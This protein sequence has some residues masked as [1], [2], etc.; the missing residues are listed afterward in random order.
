MKHAIIGTAG[1]VDHGKTALVKA[2]TGTDCDR[3]KEEKERGLTIELG[4]AYLDLGDGKGASIVDVPGHERF[5]KTMLAGAGVIDC[6]LFVIA[7]DEG[8]MPQTIEHFDIINLLGIKHGLI[9]LTK[10]DLTGREWLQLVKEDIAEL[11]R[12]TPFETAPTVYASSVTREGIDSLKEHIE[13]LLEGVEP[14]NEQR[15]F[16]FPVDWT[17]GVSGIGPII[18]GI[19]FSGKA[20]VGDRLEIVPQQKEVR[21]R[22]IQVH[23]E[24]AE[25]M[26]A[27]QLVAVNLG[28]IELSEIRRGDVLSSP[29]YLRPTYMLDAR[30][31][32]L[33]N[34]PLV[35]KDRTRIRLHLA[36]SEVLG[37][38]V[39]LDKEKLAPGDDAF[40][41]FR[42]EEQLTAEHGDRFVIRQY[43]P[44]RTIG[45]GMILDSY[46][47]KHKRFRPEIISHLKVMEKGSP[48]E[49]IEQILLKLRT[50]A[51]TEEDLI[52]V[53][54]IA[55]IE[56]KT[57]LETLISEQKVFI[58]GREVHFMH[59][60][61]YN[62]TKAAITDNLRQ[63]HTERPLKLG[64]SREELRT[65]LPFDTPSATQGKPYKIELDAYSR[66]LQNLM[67]EGTVAADGE[68]ERV[69]LTSHTIKLSE[70]HEAIKQQIEEIFLDTDFATPLPEDVLGKWSGK[71][72]QIAQEVFDVLVE[73]EGLI[74]VDE[75]VFLHPQMIDKARE[76]IVKHIRSHG[77]LTLKDCRNLLQTSRKYMLP[78]LYYFDEIGVTLRVGDD[79]VLRG[80][81]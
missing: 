47:P 72:A 16:R 11:V 25:E 37:R 61:W 8:V 63:F 59:L 55:P 39:L 40:V 68:G 57:V 33:N 14:R 81:I 22:G 53:S 66:I 74:Q 10:V 54:N 64:M 67:A 43:S 41:Q 20:K 51:S 46:P 7:A 52:K 80:G 44:T 38:V 1:H 69:R 49:R 21:V 79:R 23:G 17:F 18:C 65:K 5:V 71:K 60:D 62:K 9:V 56:M 78:I 77:K 4:Y 42:L 2:L 24:D 45:G 32:L 19:I 70:A 13:K 27:G 35:L 3:L 48:K 73:T 26:F 15:I 36:C 28:G 6:V 76:L 50:Q 30:L 34:S 75:K 29:G 12:G 58:F 31:R